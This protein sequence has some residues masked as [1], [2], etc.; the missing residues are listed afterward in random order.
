MA[1]LLDRGNNG[2]WKGMSRFQ[3]RMLVLRVAFCVLMRDGVIGLAVLDVWR[4]LL[5]V[6]R[7]VCVA[8]TTEVHLTIMTGQMRTPH[9]DKRGSQLGGVA[10]CS[11]VL[12]T[13]GSLGVPTLPIR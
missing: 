13:A 10:H 11:D 4:D 3:E 2:V 12:R 8:V 7:D 9:A 1:G 6:L 5:R